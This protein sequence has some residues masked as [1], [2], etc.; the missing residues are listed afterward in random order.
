V[1][2]SHILL[3]VA[4]D[5]GEEE[6]AK[7]KSEMQSILEKARNGGDFAELAKEYSECPS[8]PQGGDLGYFRHGQMVKP[9][10]E[11]AFALEKGQISDIVETQF[12]YHII[13]SVDKKPAGTKPLEEVSEDIRRI[14]DDKEVSA[15]LKK[16]LEPVKEKSTIKIM[17]KG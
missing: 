4:P 8:A 17:V 13:L 5:A 15:A 2:A 7:V 12:G 16:W 3:K 14:L 6:K 9:F 11:A 1:K 10:D